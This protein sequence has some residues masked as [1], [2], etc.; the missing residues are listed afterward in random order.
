[1]KL[2]CVPQTLWICYVYPHSPSVRF[3]THSVF[4]TDGRSPARPGLAACVDTRVIAQSRNCTGHCNGRTVTRAVANSCAVASRSTDYGVV[5]LIKITGSL[6]SVLESALS[7]GNRYCIGCNGHQRP[8]TRTSSTRRSYAV[9]YLATARKYA[10]ST[11]V[12]NALV[13]PMRLR[14]SM[15]G[16]DPLALC[17]RV[18]LS[19]SS[20]VIKNRKD[21]RE[22]M[23]TLVDDRERERMRALVDDR[24]RERMRTLVDDRERERMRTLVD[25]RERERM[26]TL[27]D[28]R[29]R[30]KE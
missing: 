20:K 24:E 26:R 12:G 27:V 28:D 11:T 2:L 4:V 16:G 8:P 29:E 14:L 13:T 17:R 1:M 6:G 3:R 30:E 5:P 23:R 22:R 7:F 19:V 21:L 15:R 25:D 10:V 9:G 18:C